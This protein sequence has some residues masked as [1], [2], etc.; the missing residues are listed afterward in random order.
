MASKNPNPYRLQ[1]K[2]WLDI[3]KS[4]EESIADI[5]EKLKNAR[6]YSTAIR[7]GL[8]L[9]WDLSQG[10]TDVLLE[11]FPFVKS[12]L[13]GTS[14]DDSGGISKAD[15]E[16]LETL[17]KESRIEPIAPPLAAS[18]L[19]GLKPLGGINSHSAGLV[20]AAPKYDDED[21]ALTVTKAEGGGNDATSNFLKSM[22]ALQH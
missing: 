20:I 9:F 22:L 18:G 16:R 1:F 7:D 8:R 19:G 17:I 13:A 12:A 21:M 11:L 14:G 6:K 15:L 3:T 2:F 10:K 4:N 5:I